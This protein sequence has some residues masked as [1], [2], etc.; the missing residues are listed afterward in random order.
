MRVPRGHS[1]SA[2]IAWRHSPYLP[3]PHRMGSAEGQSPSARVWGIPKPQFPPS[4]VLPGREKGGRGDEGVQLSILAVHLLTPEITSGGDR[5]FVE[6]ARR[7]QQAGAEVTLI[8]P[9]IAARRCQEE[10]S[11]SKMYVLKGSLIDAHRLYSR[12]LFLLP[13]VYLL[14]A[15]KSCRLIR[16]AGGEVLYTTGDFFCDTIPAFYHR[17]KFPQTRWVATIFHLNESPFKRRGNTF[18]MSVVSWVL[19]RFS[20]VLIKRLADRVFLLNH[21]VKE[22][23]VRLGFS[24]EKLCVVGAGI[25]LAEINAATSRSKRGPEGCFLG[26]LNPSKGIFDL[27]EIWDMVVRE[28]PSA[29]LLIIGSGSAEWTERL[30]REIQRRGLEENITIAGFLPKSEVYSLMKS[31]RV[32]LSTSYEEGWG[33]AMA[34][35]LACRLPV[36][37]YDLPAYRPIFGDALYPIPRGDTK[38]FATAIVRLL[39]DEDLRK[40]MTE[41]AYKVVLTYDWDRVAEREMSLIR[42]LL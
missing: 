42:E 12:Y 34:E 31:S 18:I 27:P 28:M 23:L 41:Q 35:A 8:V 10:I 26:R 16:T 7:W 9:E 22:R 4:P 13:L 32:F 20:F 19:Q 5:A 38:Q 11:P 2:R 21:A 30:K 1:P 14:R 17:L 3:F 40:S 33:I 15:L 6:L 24:P 25:S 36:I 29:R 37:A 39:Q